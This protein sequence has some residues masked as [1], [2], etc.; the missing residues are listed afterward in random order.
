MPDVILYLT[1]FRFIRNKKQKMR[2]ALLRERNNPEFGGI[3][4]KGPRGG[5]A[6]GA[7]FIGPDGRTLA[8]MPT[9]TQKTDSKEYVLIQAIP[10][11]GR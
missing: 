1:A 4:D 6:S 3:E 11:S 7:W 9:S 10:I 2:L 5:W 8:Q